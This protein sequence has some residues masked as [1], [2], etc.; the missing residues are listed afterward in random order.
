MNIHKLQV[1]YL[2]IGMYR[3]LTCITMAD[4]ND[5]KC[6][7]EAVEKYKVSL[8]KQMS[9]NTFNKQCT[10]QYLVGLKT[11][12]VLKSRSLSLQI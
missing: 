10:P 6:V 4:D 12:G 5:V 7:L 1:V 9:V 11:D 8:A 3:G 2:T